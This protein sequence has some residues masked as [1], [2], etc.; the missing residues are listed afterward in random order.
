MLGVTVFTTIRSPT[1]LFTMLSASAWLVGSTISLAPVP[2]PK[3]KLCV[4]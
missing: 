2:P 4:R 3:F 1:V